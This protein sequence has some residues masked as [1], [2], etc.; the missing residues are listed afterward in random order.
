M[1]PAKDEF[2]FGIVGLDNVTVTAYATKEELI[3]KNP[4]RAVMDRIK[5]DG[6][7]GARLFPV[8]K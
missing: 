8:K 1:K 6:A 2:K 7:Q 5:N 4:E 3:K